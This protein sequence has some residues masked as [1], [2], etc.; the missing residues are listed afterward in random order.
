MVFNGC[1]CMPQTVIMWWDRVENS[2]LKAVYRAGRIGGSSLV[3]I[4]VLSALVPSTE[5]ICVWQGGGGFKL[6]CGFKQSGLFRIRSLGGLKGYLGGGFTIG[7]EDGFK[8]SISNRERRQNSPQSQSGAYTISQDSNV[9]SNVISQRQLRLIQQRKMEEILRAQAQQEQVREHQKLHTDNRRVT[10]SW[11]WPFSSWFSS[12]KDKK[13]SE[14]QIEPTALSRRR[15]SESRQRKVY[16]RGK[17]EQPGRSRKTNP[18]RML[19][20]PAVDDFGGAPLVFKQ[21]SGRKIGKG[22]KAI[23][24]PF[25]AQEMPPPPPMDNGHGKISD[26]LGHLKMNKKSYDENNFPNQMMIPPRDTKVRNSDVPYGL[27]MLQNTENYGNVFQMVD[28]EQPA[29]KYERNKD[30][31]QEDIQETNIAAPQIDSLDEEFTYNANIFPDIYLTSTTNNPAKRRYLQRRISKVNNTGVELDT[32]MQAPGAPQEE[33]ETDSPKPVQESPEEDET[34]TY[35]TITDPNNKRKKIR[36]VPKG[37]KRRRLRKKKKKSQNEKTAEIISAIE[38]IKQQKRKESSESESKSA[39][40]E[41]T[42]TPE[43]TSKTKQKLSQSTTTPKYKKMKISSTW[44]PSTTTT[45]TTTTTTRPPLRMSTFGY[46]EAHGVKK[47]DWEVPM[48]TSTANYFA[49]PT[50]ARR[51]DPR[52]P[53]SHQTNLGKRPVIP[54]EPKYSASNFSKGGLTE[55]TKGGGLY[56]PGH[57]GDSKPKE[58]VL[59]RADPFYNYQPTPSTTI[60]PFESYRR[61]T[62]Q[63]YINSFYNPSSTTRPSLYEQFSNQHKH[64]QT[65]PKIVDST[66]YGSS[67]GFNVMRPVTERFNIMSTTARSIPIYQDSRL[68]NNQFSQPNFWGSIQQTDR[69]GPSTDFVTNTNFKKMISAETGTPVKGQYDTRALSYEAILGTNAAVKGLVS[70]VELGDRYEKPAVDIR[71][72]GEH[73]NSVEQQEPE[74]ELA[75]P[76]PVQQGNAYTGDYYYVF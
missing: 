24:I 23:G 20:P 58:K 55:L 75:L 26:P 29:G 3:L 28:S 14:R 5:S 30:F 33:K 74:P 11:S 7:D 46:H 19:M 72:K 45:T 49:Q 40:P 53:P 62:M 34:P 6:A 31:E 47:Y 60:N 39:E 71:I 42:E 56:N 70:S 43:K 64:Q 68:G 52:F 15:V 8:D 18:L 22:T 44:K 54:T 76:I 10:R 65:V 27:K 66:I 69:F 63:S 9:P 16:S 4:V 59:N 67:Q 35:I 32:M 36:I 38:K 48:G 12:K 13:K 57:F 21:H 41:K 61:P 17:S 25:F 50:P 37:Q 73:G 1:S 51:Y 2:L